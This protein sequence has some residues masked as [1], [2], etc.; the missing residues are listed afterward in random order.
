[1]IVN[2]KS[3]MDKKSGTKTKMKKLFYRLPLSIFILCSPASC[4]WSQST[5]HGI[6]W[7]TVVTGRFKKDEV[8][9]KILYVPINVPAGITA[10]NMTATITDTA[11]NVLDIGLFDERGIDPGPLNG[12][13][14]WAGGVSSKQVHITKEDATASYIPG[15]VNKGI[16]N[17]CL[18]KIKL[19]EQS[20]PDKVFHMDFAFIYA[21]LKDHDKAFYYLNKTYENRMGIACLG[22]IFC[23]RFPLL[24]ELRSDER[25]K[26]LAKKMKID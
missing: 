22:M 20:E 8:R 17:E 16:W 10:F 14:G 18:E 24:K 6:A 7:D 21:G 23:I 11:N 19:R 3:N 25:F 5:Q 9:K 13:R 26:E 1:M 2:L 12:F 15:P 4:I